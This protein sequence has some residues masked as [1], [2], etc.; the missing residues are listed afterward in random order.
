MT[1]SAAG[2]GFSLAPGTAYISSAYFIAS[3]LLCGGHRRRPALR[4]A[5]GGGQVHGYYAHK[6]PRST[7]PAAEFFFRSWTR[8][9]AGARATGPA[10]LILVSCNV[11]APPRGGRLKDGHRHAV[12]CGPSG[13]RPVLHVWHVVLLRRL[14]TQGGTT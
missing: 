12:P 4:A 1:P 3:S 6:A 5:A 13:G 8:H 14:P 10:P 11:S 7:P 2:P 9:R